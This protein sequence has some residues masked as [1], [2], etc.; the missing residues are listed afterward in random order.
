MLTL[1]CLVMGC[2][3]QMVSKD[4]DVVIAMFNAHTSTHTADAGR[5]QD[6]DMIN[7]EKVARPN[8]TKGML[9]DSWSSFQVLW[10]LY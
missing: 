10:K 2:E 5:N 1:G 7:S 3:E 9:M 4:K 8:V 6:S